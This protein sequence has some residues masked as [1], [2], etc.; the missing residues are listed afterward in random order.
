MRSLFLFV[1][2]ILF[3]QISNGQHSIDTT[4]TSGNLI[5]NGTLVIPNRTS[6]Y[7]IVIMAHG[8]GANNRNESFTPTGANGTC[9]Y[10]D[11]VNE[12]SYL[13][14]DIADSLANAGI[15]TFRYDKRTLTHGASLN[16]QTLVIQDFASDLSAA[17]DFVKLKPEI[18]PSKIYL[19]GHS[20]GSN[21]IPLVAQER[22][23]IYGLISMGGNTTP[24]DTIYANQTRDI[25]Y[26]CDQDTVTG[27]QY[28]SDIL[29]AMG[30]VRN[31]S[32]PNNQLL[33]GAYEPFWKSW[34][35]LTD[36]I[37]YNYKSAQKR[38]LILQGENDFNVPFSELNPF[39]EL[40]TAITTITSFPGLNHHFNDGD[41]P[42]TNSQ[43]LKTMIDW[44]L[45]EPSSV[46]QTIQHELFSFSI[47]HRSI[48]IETQRHSN[49]SLS[50]YDLTGKVVLEQSVNHTNQLQIQHNLKGLYIILLTDQD[51]NQLSRKSFLH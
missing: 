9:L 47:S 37:V 24:I 25:S 50:V 45:A 34:I 5:L 44:I 32:W 29:N 2:T 6:S 28:Y 21:F 14:K 35:D 36:S 4:F 20:Q 31:G 13:F 7:P 42:A 43:V 11:L 41:N 8:S 12:T 17:V 48:L 30:M 1:L 46:Q 16:L 10:P 22:Q 40:D 51:G 23:D 39:Y 18:N 27:D 19:L 15:A 33:L 38:A 49:L 26:K 3:Y